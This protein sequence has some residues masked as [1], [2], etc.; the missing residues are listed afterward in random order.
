MEFGFYL[1]TFGS[2]AKR[3][4]LLKIAGYAESLG[5]DAMVVS[6]NVV[7]PIDPKSQYP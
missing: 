4:P 3:E 5:Y 1:P 2:L 6:D 7:A